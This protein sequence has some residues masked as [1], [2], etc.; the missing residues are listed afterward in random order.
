MGIGRVVVVM[1]ALLPLA[2]ASLHPAPVV[3]R[4]QPP[5]RDPDPPIPPPAVAPGALVVTLLD[6]GV[7]LESRVGRPPVPNPVLSIDADGVPLSR[8]AAD[9]A[10]VAKVNLSVEAKIAEVPVT[11]RARALTLAQLRTELGSDWVAGS[12][13]LLWWAPHYRENHRGCPRE[14]AIAMVGTRP[15]L[16][17]Q[18][19]RLFVTFPGRGAETAEAIDDVVLVRALPEHISELRRL[20]AFVET[21]ASDLSVEGVACR[22]APLPPG[23]RVDLPMAK[24]AGRLLIERVA[25]GEE[26]RDRP[27]RLQFTEAQQRMRF[28]VSAMGVPLHRFA[29]E[30]AR[31]ADLELQVEPD[32]AGR[33]VSVNGSDMP[34]SRVLDAMYVSARV[35]PSKVDPEAPGPRLVRIRT[36]GSNMRE[37]AVWLRA[38][39][40]IQTS[41]FIFDSAVLAAAAAAQLCSRAEEGYGFEVIGSIGNVLLVRGTLDALSLAA[42]LQGALSR[43]AVMADD[44]DAEDSPDD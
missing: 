40:E 24:D 16:A 18:L 41:S 5:P 11:M 7:P 6:A 29:M 1:G 2:C 10:K 19:A 34:L 43:Q 42:R 36:A 38:S 20:A 21:N 22:G 26:A 31:L 12:H 14:L 13:E 23:A 3:Y 17:D 27:W 15:E 4:A 8:F 9:V 35:E 25:D 30:L 37:L 32:V 28:R 33:P 39:R 44:D